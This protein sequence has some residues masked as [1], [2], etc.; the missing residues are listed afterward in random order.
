MLLS[1]SSI[2]K[3]I[4]SS[5]KEDRKRV[6]EALQSVGLP[7]GKVRQITWLAELVGPQVVVWEK[8]GLNPAAISTLMVLKYLS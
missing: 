7:H 1:F 2:I 3:F 8:V 6:Q 5:S 4:T